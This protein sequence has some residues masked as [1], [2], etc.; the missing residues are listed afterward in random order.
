MG[1]EEHV[2]ELNIRS[3]KAYSGETTIAT[4]APTTLPKETTHGDPPQEE[5]AQEATPGT[6]GDTTVTT[7][8]SPARGAGGTRMLEDSPYLDELGQ[9]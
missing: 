7:E 8:G 2:A 9:E 1:G 5:A 6:T 3:V 4:T